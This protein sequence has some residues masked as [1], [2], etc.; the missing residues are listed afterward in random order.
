VPFTKRVFCQRVSCQLV[1]AEAGFDR[2]DLNSL[3]GDD[4]NSTAARGLRILQTMANSHL[5][6]L[7]SL[8]KNVDTLKGAVQEGLLEMVQVGRGCVHCGSDGF[9]AGLTSMAASP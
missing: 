8:M 3:L 4:P 7:S 2:S 5:V 1:L 9:M 6:S